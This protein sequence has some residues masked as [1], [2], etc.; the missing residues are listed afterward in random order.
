MMDDDIIIYDAYGRGIGRIRL[1][2]N[3]DKDVYD[4]FGHK[5]GSYIWNTNTTYDAFGRVVARGD[6]S[7]ML[8]KK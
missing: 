4:Y 7:T 6:A 3:G 2:G 5:L 8:L 1:V